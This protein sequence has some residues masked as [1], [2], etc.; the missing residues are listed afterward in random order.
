MN[1]KLFFEEFRKNIDRDKI[2]TQ[3]E[4]SALDKFLDL[5][6]KNEKR[7]SVAQWAYIFATTCHETAYTF[8]PVR[9]SYWLNEDWRRK[10]LRY[11]PSTN[12]NTTKVIQ[13][14]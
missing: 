5:Y 10:N 2:L 9:E 14:F 8:E 1:R 6:E 13:N 12:F 4:V 7:F 3:R 11:L